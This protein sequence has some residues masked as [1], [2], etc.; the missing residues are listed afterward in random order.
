V[1]G[2]STQRDYCRMR[3]VFKFRVIARTLIWRTTSRLRDRPA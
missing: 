2:R 3:P 1:P